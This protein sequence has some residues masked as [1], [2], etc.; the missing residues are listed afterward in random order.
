MST[1]REK[2]EQ[3]LLETP[4]DPFLRYLLA[5]E[6]FKEGELQKSFELFD[7]LMAEQPPYIP[8]FLM[9]AQ[10]LFG[11]GQVERAR[12]V[13]RQGIESARAAGDAHAA[14][15]MGDLLAQLGSAGE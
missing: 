14:A 6:W 13:L 15:E 11:D 4:G 10:R 9:A 3:M 8:A 1:R 12:T 2:T 7:G 5:M